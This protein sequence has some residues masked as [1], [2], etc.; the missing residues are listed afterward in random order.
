MNKPQLY[1]G[2]ITL[3]QSQQAP[4]PLKKQDNP[5]Q[6]AVLFW[7][8]CAFSVLVAGILLRIVT[9]VGGF[10]TLMAMPAI[11]ITIALPILMLMGLLAVR[12]FPVTDTPILTQIT[13]EFR[14]F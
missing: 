11:S 14:G 4:H 3:D 12:T 5:H 13:W 2:R 10:F 8:A 6:K 1:L 9:G 7:W